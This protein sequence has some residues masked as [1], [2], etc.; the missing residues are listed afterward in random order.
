MLS[1]QFFTRISIIDALLMAENNARY[2]ISEVFSGIE[3][4]MR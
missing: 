2:S 3:M 4:Q 1:T